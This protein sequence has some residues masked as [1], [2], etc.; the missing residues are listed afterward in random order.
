[1]WRE[2]GPFDCA[3]DYRLESVGWGIL[4]AR[5]GDESFHC[6]ASWVGDALGPFAA[7]AVSVHDTDEVRR[8]SWYEEPGEWAWVLTPHRERVLVEIRHYA[9]HLNSEDPGYDLFV[10]EIGRRDFVG[11]VYLALDRFLQAW[12]VEGYRRLGGLHPFPIHDFT[13]LHDIVTPWLK[14]M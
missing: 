11:A 1:M 2:S 7:A 9:D 5:I 4:R 14:E 12:G 10:G 13:R 8:F 3:F 6:C